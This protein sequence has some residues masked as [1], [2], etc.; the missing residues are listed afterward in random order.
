M[1]PTYIVRLNPELGRV[2]RMVMTAEGKRDQANFM[3]EAFGPVLRRRLRKAAVKMGVL[4]GEAVPEGV[5]RDR[6]DAPLAAA[7][8]GGGSGE[9]QSLP[10]REGEGSP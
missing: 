5:G 9:A 8:P 4:D 10:A 1:K 3:D 2:L 7:G 6:G